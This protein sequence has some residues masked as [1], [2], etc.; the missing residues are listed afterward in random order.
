MSHS[1]SNTNRWVVAI[2]G[3]GSK[4]AGAIAPIN[5][6]GCF[7]L[8]LAVPNSVRLKSAGVGSAAVSTWKDARINLVSMLDNLLEQTGASS[9]EVVHAVLMLAGAGRPDDVQRVTESLLERSSFRSCTQLTIT[10]DIG[11]L[12]QHASDLDPRLPAIVVIAGTGSLVGAIDK[13]GRLI[14]AGGWGPVLG[15]EASGWRI[16]LGALKPICMWIDR[17]SPAAETPE[18]LEV[19]TK[20]L[21]DKRL[22]ADREK[23][24]SALIALASDRH[25][26][27]QLAP[28]ILE[29]STTPNGSATYR[30]VRGQ[31][32][33]LVKQIENVYQRLGIS[34]DW[35]LCLAGGLASNDKLFQDFLTA[36]LKLRR[37]P[38]VSISALDPLDAGL[39]F[40]TRSG[41]A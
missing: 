3:G 19:V 5:A 11:P 24:N 21:S 20:F 39:R 40:A 32:W 9:S 41:S 30:F 29:F 35:R 16:A 17:G 1:D 33:L 36:E 2:D 6:T 4:V 23:L 14:R 8:N 38:P 26:A 28:G 13:E 12:I 34:S 7:N 31:F 10:S 37:I 22:L 25:L 18:A 15:D 27:A